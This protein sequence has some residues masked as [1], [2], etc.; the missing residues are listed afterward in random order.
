MEHAIDLHVHSTYSDGTCTPK[1]LV[2]LALKIGLSAIALTD[3][4]SVAGIKMM[5]M[6]CAD[7]PINFIPGIELSTAF[8]HPN[9]TKETEVHILGYYIDEN[10]V[11]F[12][13]YLEQYVKTRDERNE[14]IVAL[15]QEHG[16]SISMKDLK[17]VYKNCVLTRAHIARYLYD[18]SQVKSINQAFST[19]L[20]DGAKCYVARQK[21]SAMEAIR[22][23]H[24]ANGIA[25]LAHPP[26]YKLSRN[27]LN[28]MVAILS[29]NGLD[30]IEAFYSTYHNDQTSHMKQLARDNHLICTGGSDFHGSNKPYIH[31]GTGRG[32]LYIHDSI[33]YN[34][35]HYYQTHHTF[36]SAI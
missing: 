28:E 31:L 16:L 6:L 1:E 7:Y 24:D 3:H 4:D 12:L 27:E 11:D 30:G 22:L 26:L 19:Y 13:S 9:R 14:K 17:A 35:V 20:S 18:T 10:N 33:Y 34:L 8:K 2:E 23:I 29:D 36:D 5:K 15:L 21:I 25:V 32:N